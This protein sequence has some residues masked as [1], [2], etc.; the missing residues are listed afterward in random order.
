MIW[1]VQHQ[2]GEAKSPETE[3]GEPQMGLG[4]LNV[5]SWRQGVHDAAPRAAGPTEM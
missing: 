3:V 2:R 4:C 1:V 5:E